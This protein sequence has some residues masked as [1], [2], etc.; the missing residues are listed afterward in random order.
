[1]VQT[2]EQ[3]PY[4]SDRNREPGIFDYSKG[5]SKDRSLPYGFPRK[6]CSKMAWKGESIS[7]D[8]L[9]GTEAPFLVILRVPHLLEIDAA[10]RHFQSE[11]PPPLFLPRPKITKSHRRIE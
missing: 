5:R 3:L 1:M 7:L 4:F 6:L 10:L 11:T 9:P 2:V 8:P